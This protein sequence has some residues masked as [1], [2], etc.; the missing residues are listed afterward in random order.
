MFRRSALVVSVKLKCVSA[1][2]RVSSS[3]RL[4]RL[5]SS[6]STCDAVK[7]I[8]FSRHLSIA[9]AET[10]NGD[11]FHSEEKQRRPDGRTPVSEFGQNYCHSTGNYGGISGRE[12]NSYDRNAGFGQNAASMQQN[13]RGFNSGNQGLHLPSPSYQNSEGWNSGGGSMGMAQRD[14]YNQQASQVYQNHG[15]CQ[16]KFNEFYPGNHTFQQTSNKNLGRIDHN[17]YPNNG[18]Y[19]N[20]SYQQNPYAFSNQVGH[21]QRTN[22][23]VASHMETGTSHGFQQT[24][25]NVENSPVFQNRPNGYYGQ[26]NLDSNQGMTNYIQ[27]NGPLVHD[28]ENNDGYRGTIDELDVLCKE[29][30]A[31]ELVK[32]LVLLEKQGITV[33]LSRYCQMFQI[34]GDTKS[35]EEARTIHENLLKCTIKFEIKIYNKILD[36]YSKCGSMEDACKL[37][38]AMPE[39]NLTSWDTM[40]MGFANNGYGEEA[41]DL[42]AE[43]KQKGLKP[44]GCIFIGVF[45]ACGVLGAVDEGMLHFELMYK[46]HGIVPS[47]EH[48]VAIVG[49]LGAAGHL[50]EALEFIEKKMPCD[51]SV[52]VWEKL[53]ISCRIQGNVDLGNRCTEIVETIDSAKLSSESK[54]GL[55]PVK[56]SDMVK[57][58]KKKSDLLKVRSKVHEYRAGDR[59]H[60]EKDRIYAQ[61]YSL[62]PQMR[63]A[64]YVPDTRFVLH[65]IDPE[66]KEEALL[67]HSERLA[68][69]FAMIT[70]SARSPIRI[71]KNLRI[72]G[73]C[74]TA[75]KIVS[76]LV[77]RQFIIR[78]TKRFHHMENGVCSC[79]DYW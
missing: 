12:F 29:N 2:S 67:S 27:P 45:H 63:E 64:G 21:Q 41:L 18:D 19:G 59:S 34:C 70:S 73:D 76:K 66:S 47:M 13:N 49:M 38:D 51:P 25:S 23:L 58:E 48:Y 61:L 69:A 57:K 79:K 42:F 32:V 30:K 6:T 65:D 14:V 3:G 72:C 55:V 22:D 35:L 37:F 52:C 60:P 68:T 74:H 16:Q 31:S 53:M 54:S 8:S 39:R 46:E 56:P 77:G 62:A 71:I 10:T 33:D 20:G 1:I 5:R 75:L 78:D 9:S 4:C 26:K 43:F 36:M 15:G 7:N 24:P 40:I 11:L 44:D 28:V 50:E 17:P